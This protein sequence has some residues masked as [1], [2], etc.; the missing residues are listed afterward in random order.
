VSGDE[1][2]RAVSAL[3]GELQERSGFQLARTGSE[4]NL[5]EPLGTRWNHQEPRWNQPE[6]LGTFN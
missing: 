3:F 2:N 4:P 1:S 6:P 5:L